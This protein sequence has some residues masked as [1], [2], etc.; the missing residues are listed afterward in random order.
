MWIGSLAL[1]V[2]LLSMSVMHFMYIADPLVHTHL[3][4]FFLILVKAVKDKWSELGFKI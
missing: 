1:V 4:Y 3:K 2:Q